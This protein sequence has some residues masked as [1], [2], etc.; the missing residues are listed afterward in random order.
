MHKPQVNERNRSLAQ[1]EYVSGLP[2]TQ[3]LGALVSA[4]LRTRVYKPTP[5]QAQARRAQY[6]LSTRLT[7]ARVHW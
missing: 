4:R 7:S 6:T 5:E 3:L 2:C 1:E